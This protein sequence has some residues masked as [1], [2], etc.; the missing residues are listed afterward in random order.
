MSLR[1][2]PV[3]FDPEVQHALDAVPEI[4]VPL[5]RETLPRGDVGDLSAIYAEAIGDLA[6]DH[7][8]HRVQSA[9]SDHTIEITILR[10]RGSAG[11]KL[12]TLY[13]IHGGG[14]IVGHRSAEAGR[15]A[16]LVAEHRAVGVL[17]EYRLAPED[18]YPAG[19]EDCYDGFVWLVENAARLGVDPERIVV[20]G[21]SAGGGFT[22]AV[23][24]LARDRGGPKMAGQLMLCPML[25]N[26]NSTVSSLQYDG[27]GTWQRSAALLAWECVLGTDL[28]A[29]ESAPAYAAPT[30]A[31]DLSG[32]PPAYIEV[33]AAEMFRDE[34]IEY[35]SR[36]WATG[37]Q[38][39]LHVWSG[40]CHGFDIYM[41]EIEL[42]RAALAARSSWLRRVIR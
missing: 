7:E 15:I 37:G 14:M 32:L 5:T 36:I 13:N 22:A 38:A 3:P 17:V 35:A 40:G 4:S 1:Y 21:G 16:E 31:A 20:M 19:V 26:T 29:S 39:E 18:P 11:E 8:E 28:A 42:T 9:T 24:L 12:P 23:A 6:I 27:I 33:G 41:P 34:D 25:D 30:R 10:P 2:P